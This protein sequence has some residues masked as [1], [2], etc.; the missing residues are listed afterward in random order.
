M[1]SVYFTKIVIYSLLAFLSA[2]DF[3]VYSENT[4]QKKRVYALEKELNARTIRS[5]DGLLIIIGSLQNYQ[6]ICIEQNPKIAQENCLSILVEGLTMPIAQDNVQL[7]VQNLKASK[8]SDTTQSQI[9]GSTVIFI[10]AVREK[11][12]KGEIT[13][14][15]VGNSFKTD[16]P[17]LLK[18]EK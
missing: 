17:Y 14:H 18:M 12:Y 2:C 13:P 5:K 15:A 3:G 11:N 1:N 10:P 8:L 16:K 9:V 6:S 7:L 4:N